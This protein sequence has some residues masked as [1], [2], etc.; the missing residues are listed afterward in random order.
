MATPAKAHPS[1]ATARSAGRRRSS[2]SACPLDCPDA[3]SLTSPSSTGSSSRSTARSKNPVTGGYIC[4]KVR[5]FGERVYGPDR[6]L[7]PAV[8]T[9]PQGRKANSPASTWDEA[10]EL[11]VERFKA[12]ASTA[13]GIVDSAL[14]LRRFER[15]DDARQLRR[16]AVA[17]IRHVASR[18]HCVR[19]T[20]RRRE[21]RAL[22]QDAVRHLPG[23]PRSEADRAV[24]REPDRVGHSSDPVRPRSAEA[25]GQ[26]RCDRPA[27][28]AA[29]AFR[30][31]SSRHQARHR[32]RR[33]PR[34]SI[35][36]FSRTV[37]PTMRSFASIRS[38]GNSCGSAPNRGRS[39]A[40]PRPR[41]STRRRS[42][43]LRPCT[44]RARR[45]SSAA[46]GASSGTATAATQRWRC[47]RCLRSA[48]SSAS[49]AAATR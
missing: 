41:A 31:Y 33:R 23:L 42:S 47:S 2:T 46:D 22:R 24:G 1:R 43:G 30:G 12:A 10:L 14:L 28:H 45:R 5:K 32:R 49:G 21:H 3:C 16:D 35:G 37:T 9:R 29:R 20:D 15:P 25:R 48:A 17:P 6:I 40:P 13:G 19:G 11:I 27:K 8:R 44:R 4:A 7:H 39:S 34:R 18:A 38:A 36:T 26:A